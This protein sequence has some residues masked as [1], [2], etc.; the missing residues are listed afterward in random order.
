MFYKILFIIVISISFSNASYFDDEN[1]ISSNK[2]L[3]GG[4]IRQDVGVGITYM[5]L[6]TKNIHGFGSIGFSPFD[7]FNLGIGSQLSWR[8]GQ[9]FRPL[10]GFGVSY[11]GGIEL[12]N[13]D[14]VTVTIN[15]VETDYKT[16]SG[17]FGFLYTGVQWRVWKS[18]G[19]QYCLGYRTAF[20]GGTY[21]I[22]NS[23]NEE[24]SKEGLDSMTGPG[25]TF[26]GKMFWEF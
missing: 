18:F 21:K 17:T 5:R 26:G 25:L 9:R 15:G 11:V 20:S 23:A 1:E 8:N 7:G 16:E 22:N 14:N 13:S 10:F 3:I 24:L 12:K 6:I 19:L 4:G 2:L